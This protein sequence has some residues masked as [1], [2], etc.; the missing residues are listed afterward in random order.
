MTPNEQLAIHVSDA[1]EIYEVNKDSFSGIPEENLFA[2]TSMTHGAG[3]VRTNGR[4]ALTV[5]KSDLENK[6]KDVINDITRA[7]I[8]NNHEYE[9]LSSEVEIHV[10]FSLCG[11]IGCGTFINLAYLIKEVAP[12]C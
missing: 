11:G 10:V 9:L 2:L 12:K 5:Y 8:S 3:Q 6:I 7:D 1:R 4:F